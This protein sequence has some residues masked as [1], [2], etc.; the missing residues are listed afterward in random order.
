M[1]IIYFLF[2]PHTWRT[3]SNETEENNGMQIKILIEINFQRDSD[4]RSAWQRESSPFIATFT[5]SNCWKK[6]SN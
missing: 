3:G 2:L 4:N 5:R 1:L 6:Q